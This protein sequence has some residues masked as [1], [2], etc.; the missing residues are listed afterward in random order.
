M[1][2][3]RNNFKRK[4]EERWLQEQMMLQKRCMIDPVLLFLGRVLSSS[5]FFWLLLVHVISYLLFGLSSSVFCI[6][7]EFLLPFFALSSFFCP[8]HFVCRFVVW[9][10]ISLTLSSV[11]MFLNVWFCFVRHFKMQREGKEAK[12]PV[13]F[14]AVS[15]FPFLRPRLPSTVA[16]ALFCFWVIVIGVSV[17]RTSRVQLWCNVLLLLCC[18]SSLLK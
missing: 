9:N 1:K 17:N 11:L 15:S 3:G 8:F 10:V 18:R 5:F 13:S 12:F 6:L 16:A 7:F 4:A 14:S 2:T